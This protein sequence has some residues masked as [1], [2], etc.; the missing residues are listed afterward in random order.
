GPPPAGHRLPG[1]RGTVSVPRSRTAFEAAPPG[2]LSAAGPRARVL[3]ARAA[4]RR[5][6]RGGHLR[7]RDAVRRGY[8][9]RRAGA[10][11]P[12]RSPGCTSPI[13]VLLADANTTSDKSFSADQAGPP[14]CSGRAAGRLAAPQLG[15]QHGN[16]DRI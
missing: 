3:R 9:L 6:G 7:T 2:R 11:S 1:R 4:L 8:G 15:L 16:D 14:P 12:S 5:G 10:R 13:L